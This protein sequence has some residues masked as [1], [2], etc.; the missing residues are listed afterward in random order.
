M[1]QN[2]VNHISYANGLWEGISLMTLVS[3][4]LA[5][6]IPSAR[7]MFTSVFYHSI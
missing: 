7:F 1:I 5:D 3:M 6:L 2:N 4:C